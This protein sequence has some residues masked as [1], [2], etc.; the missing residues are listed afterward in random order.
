MG[1]ILD[2]G[3][4]RKQGQALVPEFLAFAVVKLLE[5]HFAQLVDYEFTA[6]ME[7]DLDEIAAG[8]EAR[9][10]WLQ[11][12]LL[13]RR[14]ATTG[15]KE[16]VEEHLGEIDA[17]EV[18]T[19]P[20]CRGSDI[21]VRVGKYGPYLERGEER[22][23]LPPDIAPDELTAER[24]EEILAQGSQEHEL[25]VDPET[26]GTIALRAGRY[27]PYVTEV[28]EGDEKPR[29]A[30]LLKSMS[31]GDGDARGRAAAPDAAAHARR[32]RTARR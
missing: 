15:L 30:S 26:G 14:T 2:R 11:P 31:P 7:D 24:A 28:L 8:D 19:V 1:T 18:N 13:R 29:T 12:L 20:S 22:Q 16:L 27:G 23:T 3:Y 5:Q 32:V 9:T 10:E 6:R 21:V 25:G 4:V 17:R